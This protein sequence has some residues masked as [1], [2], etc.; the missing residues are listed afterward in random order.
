[1]NILYFGTICNL[2]SYNDL[3]KNCSTKPS[4]AS[5]LFESALLD[6]F[7][8][9]GASVEV[10]SFPMIPTFPHIRL[11]HF[12]GKCEKL[13]C[14]YSCRWL[15]TIN[16]P[17]LKQLSRRLDA[18]RIIKR[19]IKR[20]KGDGLIFTFSIPPFLAK[21]V[22]AYARRFHIKAVAIVP[23]LLR[24]MYMNENPNTWIHKLKNLYLA[25]ALRVQGEYDGYIY[26]TEAMRDV[27]APNKPYIVLESIADVSDVCPPQERDPSS[28]MA[29]MYAGMLH[30]KY[31]II[32]LLDAFQKLDLPAVELWLFGEGTA[33]PEITR[34][35][36]ED[37]RI[38]YWGS[39]PHDEIL[40][41]EKKA[42]LLVNPRDANEL[43]TQYSFPSK[44]TEYMLSG[45]PLLTTK[46][47][48]IPD[49]YFHYVFTVE[50][51]NSDDLANEMRRILSYSEEE[52]NRFGADA[53]R[54]ISEEKNAVVQAARILSFWEEKV[55]NVDKD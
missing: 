42:A 12:G 50:S 29:I 53:Q 17:V 21:D 5:I 43:F 46:L 13:S 51:N 52:R 36:A 7:H 49:E 22:I 28:P 18:R 3:L 26:L 41:Y 24:D 30:E 15:N 55:M 38:R 16:I 40:D 44:T 10:H 31:G 47:K 11:L 2:E 27:V 25:P 37:G 23:D 8:K 6:G 19:W 34:R 4:V 48:G 39:V 35:A 1:M 33:V 9:N 14:G 54:F 32:N 45:T 20:Y